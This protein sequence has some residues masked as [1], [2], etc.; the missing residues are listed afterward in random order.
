MLIAALAL[1]PPLALLAYTAIQWRRHEISDAHENAA[2]VA[3][4]F[5][6]AY[7]REVGGAHR[8][9]LSIARVVAAARDDAEIRTLLEGARRNHPNY[10]TIGTIDRAGRVTFAGQVPAG[11]DLAGHFALRRAVQG[12]AFAMSGWEFDPDARRARAIFALPPAPSG[13]SRIVFAVMDL[14]WLPGLAAAEDL[15]PAGS[16]VSVLDASGTIIAHWPEAAWIG[17][18]AAAD[19]GVK[20]ALAERGEARVRTTSRLDGVPRLVAFMPLA[21][22]EGAGDLHLSV[23]IPTSAATGRADRIL[24]QDLGVFAGAILFCLLILA[25]LSNRVVVPFIEEPIRIA[26]ERNAAL[27]AANAALQAEVAERRR[28]EEAVEK[29]SRAIEQTADSV[30]ISNRE[31][32]IEFVNPAFEEMTGF[33]RAEVIGRTPRLLKSGVHPSSFYESLWTTILAGRTFRS[34]M[35]NQNSDGQLYDEDQTISPVRDPSGAITHFVSTGRDITQRK[36]MDAALRRLNIRFEEEAARIASI[37]HDEAGQFLTAAHMT[38]ADLSRETEKSVSERLQEVRWHLDHVEERLRRMS[39]ELHPRVVQDLGLAEALTFLVHGFTRR[40]GIRVKIDSSLGGRYSL[41]V[42]TLLYRV[43]QEGLTNIGRHARATSAV[44]AVGEEGQTISCVIRD[45]G[46]GFDP[47]AARPE[48]GL[49]L[50]IMQDRLEAAGGTLAINSTPGR[51]TELR[52]TVPME[53]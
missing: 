53:V 13:N 52:V 36:R 2:R 23:G 40:T 6:A 47:A 20:P 30:L 10:P 19:P 39:H 18:S 7:E 42:E 37:L 31:G 44:V 27:L 3:R 46:A 43:V 22:L 49:G 8:L 38:L 5:A 17:R 1:V 45:D 29:L 25:L 16:I 50:R 41:A 33:S 15:L 14:G 34:T 48:G 32:I 28:A 24:A 26:R 4:H 51:G 12:G 21:R 11:G 35:T 9:L